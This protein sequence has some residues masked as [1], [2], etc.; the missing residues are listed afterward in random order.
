WE[1][2]ILATSGRSGFAALSSAATL[3]ELRRK[4]HAFRALGSVSEVDSALL[5]IPDD[6]A[7][8]QKI[9][10]DFAPIVAPVRVTRPQAVEVGPL[11][12]A[13]ETLKRR[14]EIAAAGGPGG[15]S[16]RRLNTLIEYVGRLVV[17]APQ[18]V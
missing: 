13:L 16:R 10:R 11:I 15:H 6:Q 8:K 3:D 7:D 5:L 9:I 18:A 2:K 17:R 14:F 1:K 4:V 12:A